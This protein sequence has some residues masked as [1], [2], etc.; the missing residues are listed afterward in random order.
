MKPLIKEED[1]GA[2]RLGAKEVVNVESKAIPVEEADSKKPIVGKD[3]NI[4]LQL[5]LEKTT[6]RDAA[7]A[8]VVTNKL[9]QHVPKQTPQLGSEKTGSAGRFPFSQIIPASSFLLFPF[10]VFA[11]DGVLN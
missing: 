5:D 2:I 6:D 10:L 9:H 8:N 7:T 3:R 11:P 1:K 4:G